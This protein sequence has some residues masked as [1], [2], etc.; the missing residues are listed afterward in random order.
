ME[1]RHQT[2]APTV[3][4]LSARGVTFAIHRHAEVRTG[5]DIRNHTGFTERD[6]VNSVKT[7]AFTVEPDALAL[8]AVPGPARIRYGQ[9]A[10]ALGVRRAALRPADAQALK[11]LDMEPGGVSPICDDPEVTVVFDEAVPAMGRVLCGSG[12]ADTTLELDVADILRVTP[13]T[14]VAPVAAS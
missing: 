9:L 6:I 1:A 2:D 8:A 11:R 13:T 3:A 14:V 10:A 4:L 7:L 5:E 12:R